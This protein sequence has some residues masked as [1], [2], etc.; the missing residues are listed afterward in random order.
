MNAL[1]VIILNLQVSVIKYFNAEASTADNVIKLK[2][3]PKFD[4]LGMMVNLNTK[5]NVF[6]LLTIYPIMCINTLFL[7]QA[8]YVFK[9]N[10]LQKPHPD[11][12]YGC[13][14]E[15]HQRTPWVT[16]AVEPIKITLLSV[17]FSHIFLVLR[18]H[19]LYVCL[20]LKMEFRSCARGR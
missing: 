7:F 11:N 14:L 4:N 1:I 9:G 12:L 13:I 16:G 15:C 18:D 5:A 10:A 17:N 3:H 2:R 19:W 6:M 8:A 20:H